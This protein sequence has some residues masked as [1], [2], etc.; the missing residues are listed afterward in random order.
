MITWSCHMQPML[1]D[2]YQQFLMIF[3][4]FWSVCGTS[5]HW[6]IKVVR[7]CQWDCFGIES[8]WHFRHTTEVTWLLNRYYEPD[9]VILDVELLCTSP[10][11][12]VSGKIY[13]L[14]AFH[15]KIL[16]Y[17]YTP[18]YIPEKQVELHPLSQNLIV[19]QNLFL[20]LVLH[21]SLLISHY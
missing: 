14:S 18:L 13:W 19:A 17:I 1:H 15:F 10:V 6:H 4:N 5:A 7:M 21:L 16:H 12:C 9:I 3:S 2:L 20:D 11:L 8:A